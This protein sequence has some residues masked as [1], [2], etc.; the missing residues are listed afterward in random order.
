[1]ILLTVFQFRI[2]STDSYIR[3]IRAESNF[4]VVETDCYALMNYDLLFCY[5][6]Y[7][8]CILW[9]KKKETKE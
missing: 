4:V 2:R 3:T 8:H 1:M 7:T 9:H 6:E 5:L